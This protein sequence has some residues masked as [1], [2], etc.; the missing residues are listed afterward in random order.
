MTRD[1]AGDDDD[2][3]GMKGTWAFID[4][5]LILAADRPPTTETNTQTVNSND[6]DDDDDKKEHDTILVG[7]VVASSGE[8]LLDNP[9][10]LRKD[11]ATATTNTAATS[12]TTIKKDDDEEKKGENADNLEDVHLSVPSGKVQIGKFFYPRQHPSFFEQPIFHPKPNGSFELKQVLGSLNTRLDTDELEEKFRKEDLMGKRFFMT[13][14]PLANKRKKKQR[15][16]I[17]Y[18]KYVDKIPKTEREKELEKIQKNL[19]VPIKTFEVELFANNTFSTIT[20]LGDM[21]LRGK[22]W[23][24]GDKRDQLWMQVWRFGFGR[25]VSGS[26]FSE[27]ST[28]SQK[29]EV[30]YWGQ[31]YKVDVGELEDEG[32]VDDEPSQKKGIR[33]EIN[34]SVMSGCGLEPCS[35]AR[36]T[37][38]EKTEDDVEYDDDNSDD[39]DDDDDSTTHKMNKYAWFQDNAGGKSHPVGLKQP[40][41]YGLYDVYG[42]V[43]ERISDTYTKDYYASSPRVSE[44]LVGGETWMVVV[45]L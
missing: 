15:W 4:G 3:G 31:I 42:N 39:D 38:I 20:G 35:S 14:F 24:I 28:L 40:N 16:S 11:N 23:I 30:T 6:D 9:A 27:G 26:T 21:V 37:M 8:R 18:N 5:N 29:D 19:P 41:P 43:C 33:V 45:K 13:S 44:C 17:K 36:F 2:G 12:S 25:S 7:R 34:G 1:K 10:L 32:S 22:W